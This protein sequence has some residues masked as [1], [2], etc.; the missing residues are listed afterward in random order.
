MLVV[1]G[2]LAVVGVRLP[3]G[4][5][6]GYIAIEGDRGGMYFPIVTMSVVSVIMTILVNSS[7]PIAARCAKKRHVAD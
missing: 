5:P 2:R 7:S 6:P 1:I 4:R 3:F